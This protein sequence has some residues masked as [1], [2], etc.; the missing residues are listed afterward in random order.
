MLITGKQNP[1]DITRVV[2]EK[3]KNDHDCNK[4]KN[5][6]LPDDVRRIK[7]TNTKHAKICLCILAAQ[8][9]FCININSDI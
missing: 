5:T 6:I 9:P 8:C 3:K 1:W 7:H 4:T 2:L